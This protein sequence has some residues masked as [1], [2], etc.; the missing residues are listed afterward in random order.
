M[1][2]SPAEFTGHLVAAV[3]IAAMARLTTEPTHV[4][5]PAPIEYAKASLSVQNAR[6]LTKCA[7]VV[8]TLARRKDR[9]HDIEI[10]QRPKGGSNPRQLGAAA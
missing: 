8:L 2:S 5:R 4:D 3:G 6:L 9:R 1:D 10:E 7:K